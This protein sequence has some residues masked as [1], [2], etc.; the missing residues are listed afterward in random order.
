MDKS[1]C[2]RDCNRHGRNANDVDINS[3]I[4]RD[5]LR[6][7]LYNKDRTKQ[8]PLGCHLWPKN[9][10]EALAK[11]LMAGDGHWKRD[12]LNVYAT[13]SIH[14]AKMLGLILE[15]L[16]WYYNCSIIYRDGRLPMYIFEIRTDGKRKSHETLYR[17]G[18]V[19]VKVKSSNLSNFKGEV[20]NIDVED[21]HNYVTLQGLQ[22]NCEGQGMPAWE[23]MACGVPVAAMEYSA[24]EDYFRCS[25]NISIDIE[26]F[27]WEAIIET[28]QKRALPN[29]NDFANKLDR[30]LRL[31]ENAR[32]EKSRKVR[33]YIEELVDTYGS[34]QKMP[35]YS[36]DRTAAIWAQVIRETKIKDPQTTWLCPTSREHHPNLIPPSNDMNNSE[37]VNWVIGKVWGRPDMLQTHFSG[38]WLKCLNSGLRAVGG[39]Q[40]QF[41]RRQFVEHFMEMVKQRNIV[42]GKRLALLNKTTP[43]AVNVEMM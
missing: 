39:N 35:R 16:G 31:T 41:S 3:V 38:D 42:E 8:L 5:Q 7:L 6:N 22:H 26:R 13:T 29:N 15:R 27:F 2:L 9:L 23:A 36:W 33:S 10:Q 14:I 43:N 12:N 1:V 19:F 32:T 30:F 28:E 4:F 18:F 21:D 17:D 11:G 34:D 25:E 40:V 24:M 20:V 37:F